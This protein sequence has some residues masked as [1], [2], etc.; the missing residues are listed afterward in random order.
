MQP[1]S[2]SRQIAAIAA[3]GSM[4]V[5]DVVPTV[6]ITQ[7]GRQPSA[8]SAYGLD[9]GAGIMRNGSSGD[10]ANVFLTDAQNHR[11]LL[12]GSMRLLGRIKAQLRH[13]AAPCHAARADLGRHGIPRGCNRKQARRRCAVGNDAFEV[14]RQPQ[15]FAQPVE[16]ALLQL[17]R[18]WRCP[19]QHGVHIERGRKKFAEN[20]GPEP[21][22]A[23]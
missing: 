12:N 18:R 16:H 1:E 2:K 9:Q 20:P 6:A 15:H 10:Q 21:V 22:M 13:T 23:K 3:T 4:L 8:I 14:G 5:V 7:K 11:A 19:P 17:G